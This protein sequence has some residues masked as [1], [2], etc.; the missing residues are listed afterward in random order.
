MQNNNDLLQK[1]NKPAECV[2]FLPFRQPESL[3]FRNSMALD[4]CGAKGRAF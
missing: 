4:N 2:V 1:R 3:R